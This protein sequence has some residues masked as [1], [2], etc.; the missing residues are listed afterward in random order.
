MAGQAGEGLPSPD[1]QSSPHKGSPGTF[2]HFRLQTT[3]AKHTSYT[4][5]SARGRQTLCRTEK[6]DSNQY[7]KGNGNNSIVFSS[8]HYILTK[9]GQ[10]KQSL[11]AWTAHPHHGGLPTQPPQ[12]GGGSSWRVP[13]APFSH[14]TYTRYCSPFPKM[15]SAG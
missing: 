1:T 4:F 7:W 15:H 2:I 9:R 12:G 5:L 14:A 11:P 13:P 10:Q 6:G 8:Q 3:A